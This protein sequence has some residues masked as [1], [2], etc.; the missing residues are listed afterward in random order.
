MQEPVFQPKSGQIDYTNIRRAPVINCVV[1]HDGKILLVQ[2]SAGMKFYPSYWNGVSGFLD[3]GRSILQKAK[4]ELREEVGIEE[5]RIVRMTEGTVFEYEEPLYDRVWVVHPVLAEVA[6]DE[7]TLDW[8][9]QKYQWVTVPEARSFHLL[10]GF[11]KVLDV[12]F[13]K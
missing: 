8:E 4:D 10:P 12:F 11:E 9:A 1:K 7:I 3:D 13:R 2:R 6:T 5:G